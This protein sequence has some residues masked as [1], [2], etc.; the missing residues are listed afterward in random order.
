MPCTRAPV[1]VFR[2]QAAPGFKGSLRLLDGAPRPPAALTRISYGF[3]PCC[4]TF[5]RTVRARGGSLTS[6]RAGPGAWGSPRVGC[7]L[8]LPPGATPSLQPV[9]CRLITLNSHWKSQVR[10]ALY[11][12]SRFC[13]CQARSFRDRRTRPLL[14]LPNEPC[15]LRR[16]TRT[17]GPSVARMRMSSRT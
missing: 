8:R 5:M 6:A 1:V 2:R 7:D 11:T 12:S 3:L 10:H 4:R 9:H 15:A 16:T 14:P 17:T 13:R